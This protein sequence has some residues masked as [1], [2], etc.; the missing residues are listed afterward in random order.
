MLLKWFACNV[1]EVVFLIGNVFILYL[2]Q[3]LRLSEPCK[4]ILK[5]NGNVIRYQKSLY[6]VT[7]SNNES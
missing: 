3:Y 1:C 5:E 4:Q 6:L 2:G 7:M